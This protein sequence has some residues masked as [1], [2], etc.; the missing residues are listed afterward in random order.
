MLFFPVTCSWTACSNVIDIQ[1]DW[2]TAL[3]SDALAREPWKS[4]KWMNMRLVFYHMMGVLLC[5]LTGYSCESNLTFVAFNLL[6]IFLSLTFICVY[7]NCEVWGSDR[8]DF[9]DS[10]L[11]DCDTL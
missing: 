6:N 9:E 2:N 4:G 3:M 8:N 10:G 11:L 1:K 5:L 7:S